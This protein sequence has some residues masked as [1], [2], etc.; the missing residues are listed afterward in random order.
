MPSKNTSKRRRS[1]TKPAP[2]PVREETP[3]PSQAEVRKLVTQAR[4]RL[5][6]EPTK[7]DHAS[8]QQLLKLYE[9][10][11]LPPLFESAIFQIFYDA[12]VH[13]GVRMPNHVPDHWREFWPLLIAR[14]RHDGHLLST[15]SYTWG[16][17][18]EKEAELDA[19][20]EEERDA[21]AIFDLINNP[22]V[23]TSIKDGFADI[24]DK[25]HPWHNFEVFRVA[26]PLALRKLAVEEGGDV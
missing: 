17:S 10:K 5:N 12:C 20:E 1:S 3:H 18:E 21:R 7:D 9:S 14:L 23:T 25:A 24:L 6:I 11:K 16:C 15:I 22:H 4:E 26:W 19:E 13:Y 8:A 2:L